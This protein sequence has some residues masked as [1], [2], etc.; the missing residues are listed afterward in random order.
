MTRIDENNASLAEQ[1]LR[2]EKGPVTVSYRLLNDPRFPKSLS[3]VMW[4]LPNSNEK[5][6][7][8]FSRELGESGM[9]VM[10][11]LL[12]TDLVLVDLCHF[13]EAVQ[14]CL[15][16]SPKTE[17]IAK[18]TLKGGRGHILQRLAKDRRI[19]A[20]LATSSRPIIDDRDFDSCFLWHMAHELDLLV[21]RR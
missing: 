4:Q 21:K 15:H 1:R 11:A 3:A 20:C 13:S 10:D 7:I 8:P 14:N 6:W 5:F 16:K 17:R 18:G 12:G 9:G 2:D 19:V